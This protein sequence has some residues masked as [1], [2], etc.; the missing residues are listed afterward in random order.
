LEAGE[1]L[2]K[3]FCRDFAQWDPQVIRTVF[4][5]SWCTCSAANHARIRLFWAVGSCAGLR[6]M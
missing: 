4:N 6:G 3:T 2:T 1:F 5:T